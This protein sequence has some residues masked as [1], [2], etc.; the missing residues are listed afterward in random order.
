MSGKY[1]EPWFSQGV[2]IGDANG[3]AVLALLGS[4]VGGTAP[5]E[6]RRERAR[7]IVACVN[8]CKG[9]SDAALEAGAVEKAREALLAADQFIKNGVALGFIRMPSPGVPD[10]AHATPGLVEQA[11][12]LLQESPTDE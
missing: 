3:E 10:P 4:Y 12:S 8:A 6:Q 5:L 11:L 9:I 1:G 7:R 2:A